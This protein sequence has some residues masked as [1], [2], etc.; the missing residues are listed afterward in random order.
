MDEWLHGFHL[1]WVRIWFEGAD[2]VLASA[3]GHFP[4]G[5]DG[6]VEFTTFRVLLLRVFS[7]GFVV[8]VRV[9]S[10]KLAHEDVTD[11][12]VP[13]AAVGGVDGV[14]V[15]D[16]SEQDAVAVGASLPDAG[17]RVKHHHLLGVPGEE[18]GIREEVEDEW[19]DVRVGRNRDEV[20]GLTASDFFVHDR[21]GEVVHGDEIVPVEIDGA[22]FHTL[23]GDS[24]FVEVDDIA[25][26]VVVETMHMRGGARVIL[27]ECVPFH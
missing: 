21:E 13:G 17:G 10:G 22:A 3:D 2:E 8:R 7:D 9:L 12:H 11:V 6:L 1:V 24:P 14:D 26:G 25:D 16:F 20:S 19:D 18:D 4:D 23:L 5:L 27:T 15:V